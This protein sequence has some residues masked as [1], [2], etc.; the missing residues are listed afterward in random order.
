M[1]LHLSRIR[2]KDAPDTAALASLLLPLEADARIAA[3]HRLMWSLFADDAER[4]RDF[5]W[6]ED[7][8]AAT[9]RKTFLVLSARPPEDKHSL[10]DVESKTFEPVLSVDQE[11]LFRLRASPGAAEATPHGQRGKRI[12]PVARAL[13]DLGP[14][15]RA[16]RRDT[17]I[18]QVGAEWLARQG[19]AAGFRLAAADAGGPPLLRVEGDAWRVLPRGEGKPLRFGSLDFEGRL[20]VEDPGAFLAALARGFGRSKAFG[21]GL[22]LIRRP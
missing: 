21:C 19:R 14:A 10:F 18:Q 4:R 11:L 15:A 22:M 1:T 16:E 13:R 20:V 3:T 2:L 7:G 8:G 9:R 6:R 17:I 5:L 12:D